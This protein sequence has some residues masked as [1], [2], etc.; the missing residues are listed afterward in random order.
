MKKKII[1]TVV[2]LLILF[3]A[4]F[5]INNPFGS[6]ADGSIEVEVVNLEGKTVE[7]K[8]IEFNKGDKLGTLLKENFDN[9]KIKDGF[10]SSIDELSTPDDYSTFICIYV[11]DK[12]SEVGLNDIE[13]KDGTN[14][15]FVDTENTYGQ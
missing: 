14:I 12:M 4:L 5:A 11:D 9:V 13:Y 7:D 2:V 6:K 1:A 8:T 3:A 15:S 10:L